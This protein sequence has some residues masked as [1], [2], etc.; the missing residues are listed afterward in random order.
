MITQKN[1]HLTNP[2][3]TAKVMAEIVTNRS[4]YAEASAVLVQIYIQN[5]D[6]KT[7]AMLGRKI[8]R[9]LPNATIVGMTN[10][11][12]ELFESLYPGDESRSMFRRADVILNL[13]RFEES[14]LC[15]HAFDSSDKSEFILGGYMGQL[16]KSERDAKGVLL[17]TSG[18]ALSVEDYLTM[19]AAENAGVPFFGATG[20]VFRL[21]TRRK[22]FDGLY[23]DFVTRRSNKGKNFNRVFYF[24]GDSL[25]AIRQGFVN[26]VFKGHD[27]HIHTGY[28]F[29]WTPIGKRM[30]LDSV[31]GERI[32]HT[33]DGQPASYIYKKYLGLRPDQLIVE[34]VCEFPFVIK[35][36]NRLLARIGFRMSEDVGALH[37]S[38]PARFRHGRHRD[39]AF[40]RESG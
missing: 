31:E 16:L 15:V 8:A 14:T 22:Y 12:Y 4:Y 26:V 28:S 1:Y 37:F 32:V 20:S 24:D 7:V 18:L 38:A 40:L 10:T 17:L 34:N 3:E 36:E 5:W 33:I 30:A 13:I 39:S 11:N 27:L 9:V 23:T 35:R 25:N 21:E 6:K 2:G 29:G 19:A